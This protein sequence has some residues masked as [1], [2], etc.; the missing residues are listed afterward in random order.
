MK[1]DYFPGLS[2][3]TF[4]KG[5]LENPVIQSESRVRQGCEPLLLRM[6][7]TDFPLK[8]RWDGWR[9]GRGWAAGFAKALSLASR[10]LRGRPVPLR[11]GE[12]G[13]QEGMGEVVP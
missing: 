1:L 7:L 13:A 5:T 10:C 11:G 4:V 2:S 9:R 6:P 3:L 12:G 8:H